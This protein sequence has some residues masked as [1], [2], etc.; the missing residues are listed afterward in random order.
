M[1][2]CTPLL[3]AVVLAG[4]SIGGSDESGGGGSA[5][6]ASGGAAP[7]SSQRQAAEKLG[8][9]VVATRNTIRVGGGDATADLAGVAAAVFP[10]TSTQDR[11]HAV[12]LVDKDDW[13]GAIAG[14]VLNAQPLGAP[15]LASDGGDLPA[16]TSD[17]I[18]RLEPTGS[19]LAR[20]A[21]V[22]RIGPKPPAPSGMK[23][24]KIS[25]ADPYATAA[26]I[27][28]FFTAIRGK[29]SPHV[30]VASGEQAPYAMPA[31]AWAA[32]SGDSVLFTRRGAVPKAT[33]QAIAAHEKPDIYVLGPESVISA[34]V[35]KKLGQLGT[36]RRVEG[37][38][39]VA[40]AVALARYSRRGFGW[41]VTVPGYNFSLA[42]TT[43]PLDAAAAA[44]LATNGVFAPMLLTSGA[45]RLPT[46]VSG[47]LLD[48][49]P[50][51]QSDPS[52]GVYNRVWILGDTKTLSL[53]AQ[54][55]LDQI[56]RLVPVE[57]RTP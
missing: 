7:T 1:R 26:A 31:A 57:T 39:P 28:R 15:L 54:G 24:G 53:D 4:C 50:G 32:R 18:E 42:S 46:E 21:Q 30:I 34:G 49:Q 44:T 19:D 5:G 55:R 33:M 22:I 29:P 41:G 38:T 10:A 48:V 9:P 56:T 43:R 17:A 2:R 16:A 40:N 25:A 3:A 12:A 13:Q 45:E 36:V 14:S 11:P 52:S 51:Y 37:P 47:Y 8:F 20:D 35:E 23:S 27:D 6:L